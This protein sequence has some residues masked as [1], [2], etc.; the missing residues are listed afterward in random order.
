MNIV[1]FSNPKLSI[2][3]KT[4][5]NTYTNKIIENNSMNG[6]FKYD[7]KRK[8][9]YCGK[10]IDELTDEDTHYIKPPQ[11]KKFTINTTTIQEN[12]MKDQPLKYDEKRK[13]LYCGKNID[14]LDLFEPSVSTYIDEMTD[15]GTHCIKPPQP[16]KLTVNTTTIQE[17]PMEDE[18]LKYDEKRKMFYRGKNID[19]LGPFKPSVPKYMDESIKLPFSKE[20]ID[21]NCESIYFV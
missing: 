21:K 4:N 6:T 9:L 10:N 1:I 5:N 18:L 14:E 19:E 17:N 2:S 7:E 11:P 12:P 3:V 20:T 13:M 15:E 16:M 8:M